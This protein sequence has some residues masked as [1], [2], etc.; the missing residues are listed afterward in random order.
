[1]KF[2]LASDYAEI[3]GIVDTLARNADSA[4]EFKALLGEVRTTLVESLLKYCD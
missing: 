2:Y 4:R 3:F 1:M